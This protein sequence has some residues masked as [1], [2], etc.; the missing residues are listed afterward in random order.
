LSTVDAADQVRAVEAAVWRL[1]RSPR[2]LWVDDRPSNNRFERSALENM[3][4]IVDLSTSTVTL[5]ASSSVV[6]RT[7]S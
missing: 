1:G 5:S 2:L 6:P 7:T 4:M 3:G